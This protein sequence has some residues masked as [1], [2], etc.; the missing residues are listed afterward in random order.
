MTR[1]VHDDHELNASIGGTRSSALD[2]AKMRLLLVVAVFMLG[3]LAISLRV[4]DLTLMRTKPEAVK[5]VK[6]DGQEIRQPDRA[7]RGS[8]L[9]RNGE[10]MATSLKMASVYANATLVDNPAALAKQLAAILTSQKEAELVKKLSS[11]KKFVWIERNITPKQEYAINALGQPGLGFQEDGRRIYPNARLTSH[12]LGYTDVDGNGISGIEKAY[13]REL[14]EGEEPVT[15][16]IDLRIQHVLHRELSKA[17]EKFSAKAAVGMVTDVNTGEVIAMV[18]LPDFDPYRAGEASA[19]SR[20]NRATLGVFE[21]GSTFKLFSTAA[22]LDTEKVNFNTQ[23][24]AIQP[25]KVGRFTISDYHAKKRALTVPEIFIYS[26]NIGTARMAMTVGTSGIKDFYKTM[27]FLDQV[28]VLFPERGTPLYP[29]PWRD[30]S[31]LTTSF[32]HGIAVSPLHLMRAAAALVNGGIMVKPSFV[33]SAKVAP[34]LTPSGERVV[35]AATSEKVRKLLELVVADGTG[36]KAAVEGYNVGGKT[37]TAEKTVV[38]GYKRD[39]LL[40]SFLGFFPINNPRYAVVA[41]LD[42]P[43][44]TSDTYGYATGGWTAA[45]V[46]ARVIE[47][48]GPLYQVPPDMDRGRDIVREMTPYVKELQKGKNVAAAGTDH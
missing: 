47:Q 41:I 20:F 2:Q 44:A 31:T 36:S 24:D 25:I 11:G 1:Q 21:M 17:M 45:P 27:G 29:K 18:S 38:G 26:S 8:I 12:L 42:E 19:D 35:K 4:I 9:D 5:V 48:M 43:K 40:S 46:V 3:Y 28:P 10:L 6:A 14:A 30:V 32:G 22:A 7:L 39:A 15:L 33:K 23:Y 34:P 37:G 16:T 13:N